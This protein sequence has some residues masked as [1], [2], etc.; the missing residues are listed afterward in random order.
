MRIQHSVMKLAEHLAA[1]G[2]GGLLLLAMLITTDVLLRFFLSSPIR[3][4]TDISIVTAAVLLAAC[5][6][7]VVATRG[8]ITVDIVGRS[9]GPRTLRAL[10]LFGASATV[11]AFVIMAWQC[12]AF[13][14]DMWRSGE[15]MPT[16]RWPVWPWW[17][18]VALMLAISALT[19]LVILPGSAR[20][21]GESSAAG[22]SAEEVL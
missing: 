16:L 15:T 17:A 12:S 10:N 1:L 8:N 11:L 4:L 13:A 20:P 5:M 19:A 14:H 7:H 18:G 2:V 6:P 9:I 21:L 3:G 22:H